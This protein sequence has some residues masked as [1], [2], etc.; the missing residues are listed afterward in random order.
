MTDAELSKRYRQLAEDVWGADIGCQAA[1]CV[2]GCEPGMHLQG[3]CS[4][5]RDRQTAFRLAVMAKEALRR[6]LCSEQP[7]P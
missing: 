4:C 7:R 3:P 6:A 5:A 1:V 2:F